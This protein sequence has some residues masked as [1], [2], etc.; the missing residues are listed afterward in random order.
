ML[1]SRPWMLSVAGMTLDWK[2]ILRE[3]RQSHLEVMQISLHVATQPIGSREPSFE[4][5]QRARGEGNL[6]R[7][8]PERAPPPRDGHRA[9]GPAGPTLRRA[10]PRTP[11]CCARGMRWVSRTSA[12]EPLAA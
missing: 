10:A 4:V 5:R 1:S 9:C 7:V 12:A 3:N 2:R 11:T 6:E 8:P